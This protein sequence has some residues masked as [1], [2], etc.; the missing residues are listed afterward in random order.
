MWRES[1]KGVG[2]HLGVRLSGKASLMRGHLRTGLNEEWAEPCGS[3]GESI[4]S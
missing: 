3:C 4:S 1:E 2:C